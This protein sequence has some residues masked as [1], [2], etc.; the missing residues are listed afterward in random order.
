M[1][2]FTL[3]RVPIDCPGC[4]HSFEVPFTAVEASDTVQCPAC[5]RGLDLQLT[6]PE[7]VASI[8]A[9]VAEL[10]R[11]VGAAALA[12]GKNPVEFARAA[13]LE[14]HL[15]TAFG[16]MRLTAAGPETVS[17]RAAH[18]FDFTLPAVRAPFDAVISYRTNDGAVTER[19]VTVLQAGRPP[20]AEAE[21]GPILLN[22]FCHLRRE[23]RTFRL[24]NVLSA[25][26][27][28]TGETAT[29]HRRWLLQKA[30]SSEQPDPLQPQR[31]WLKPPHRAVVTFR[32]R[33]RGERTAMADIQVVH[34]IDDDV[35]AIDALI[36]DDPSGAEP[37]VRRLG[38][39]EKARGGTLV[40][41]TEPAGDEPEADAATYLL[42]L[43]RRNGQRR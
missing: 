10:A 37:A 3:V 8:R 17:A 42:L 43:T 11:K 38:V 30:G 33:R 21:P 12:A 19:R 24:E 4:Q 28:E 9:A 32:G 25:H 22:G 26:D 23:A 2:L 41:V 14:Q 5:S 1:D 29:D 35:V 39:R 34:L 40:A 36:L 13:G 7:A 16:R 6:N 15:R 31:I 18:S 20:G 27:P